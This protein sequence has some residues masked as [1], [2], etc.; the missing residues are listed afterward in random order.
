MQLARLKRIFKVADRGADANKLK[1]LTKAAQ[2]TTLLRQGGNLMRQ[3]YTG[4]GYEAGVEARGHYDHLKQALIDKA[5][6]KNGGK[7]L[8]ETELGEI[9][10]VARAS[11]NGVFTGNL[12]LVGG[13]NMLML[14]KL[15]GP[16]HAIQKG[17]N[18]AM[19]SIIPGFGKGVRVAGKGAGKKAQAAYKT[20][21]L[22]QALGVPQK[23]QEFINKGLSRTKAALKIP[24]YEGIV[25]EGGQSVIDKAAYNYNMLKYGPEG[26]KTAVSLLEATRQAGIETYG[27]DDGMTEVML[28]FLIGAIG[29]PG[30][31][32]SL[33][34]IQQQLKDVQAREDIQDFMADYYNKN[35]DLL[36][37]LKSQGEFMTET[38]ELS[39]L[40]DHAMAEGNLAAWKD[41]E[42]DQL[43]S[44][45]KSK[46]M[47]GQF[48][49]I[50]EDAESLRNLS[51]EQFMELFDYNKEDFKS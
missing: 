50:V 44:Y 42:N 19:S 17:W 34:N 35:V 22:G 27:S 6:L 51:D 38:Q 43:F 24:L 14:S 16:G 13:G 5:K 3:I 31:S 36:A 46:I 8:S 41:L 20:S 45:V 37:A 10:R 9:E 12:L 32:G 4:A 33:T 21:R 2:Q 28:G 48:A 30:A 23:A 18:N 15:Y 1:E 25:E 7:E 26:Q 40:M 11:S 49:D 29:L 47:S 39:N